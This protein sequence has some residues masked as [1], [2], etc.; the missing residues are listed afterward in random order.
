[1]R[2]PSDIDDVTAEDSSPEFACRDV[3]EV[4]PIEVT[5]P[6][7]CASPGRRVRRGTMVWRPV[8]HVDIPE[9]H[10]CVQEMPLGPAL[11]LYRD[12]H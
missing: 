9:E 10:D 7:L 5:T 12:K 2:R 4:H 8:A 6:S 1:M 3:N 11:L